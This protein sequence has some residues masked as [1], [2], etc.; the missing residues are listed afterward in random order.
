MSQEIKTMS[1]IVELTLDDLN[2]VTGGYDPNRYSALM[3]Q[4]D[5]SY[6]LDNPRDEQQ[7]Q[8]TNATTMKLFGKPTVAAPCH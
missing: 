2:G 8:N 4:K 1:N 5:G 6:V 3:P 7:V